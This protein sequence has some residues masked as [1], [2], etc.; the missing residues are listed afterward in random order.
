MPS[1]QDP[2]DLE[3]FSVLDKPVVFT[4][5]NEEEE[6][7]NKY[8]TLKE[9]DRICMEALKGP[10][11]S[12]KKTEKSSMKRNT[13]VQGYTNEQLPCCDKTIANIS[14]DNSSCNCSS[15]SGYESGSSTPLSSQSGSATSTR[16]PPSRLDKR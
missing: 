15:S 3:V 11:S 4:E 1:P 6:H 2:P 13:N 9:I 10:S 14:R 5:E 16:L 12:N 7:K 8:T